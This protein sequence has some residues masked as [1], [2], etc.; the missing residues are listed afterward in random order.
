MPGQLKQQIYSWKNEGVVA[1]IFIGK[2]ALGRRIL[3]DETA[4]GEP[5]Q[6]EYFTLAEAERFGN[7]WKRKYSRLSTLSMP[8]EAAQ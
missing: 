8:S 3:P 2:P 1:P 7:T 5:D 6:K 4:Q